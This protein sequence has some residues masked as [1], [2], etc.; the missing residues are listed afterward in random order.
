MRSGI[1][2]TVMTNPLMVTSIIPDDAGASAAE[3]DHEREREGGQD[4]LR[5]TADMR[6]VPRLNAP[7]PIAETGLIAAVNLVGEE[8]END[9]AQDASRVEN[10][11]ELN[12]LTVQTVRSATPQLHESVDKLVGKVLIIEDYPEVADVINV[13]LQRMGFTTA[14]E[15]HGMRAF[16]RFTEMQPQIVMLDL[17]LPDFTGWRV[18]DAIKE[19]RG[20]GHTMPVVIVMTA[21]GDPANRLV[22]KLQGVHAYLIK[23]FTAEELQK[24]VREAHKHIS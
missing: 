19:R 21:Y 13:I 10:E 6:A 20:N 18:R 8:A 1:I 3:G 14:I 23:P 12:G 4:I 7:S 2:D 11:A 16:E 22:G 9:A 5:Q 17:A 15:S 24:V